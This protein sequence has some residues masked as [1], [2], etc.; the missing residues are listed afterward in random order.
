M[1]FANRENSREVSIFVIIVFFMLSL[2]PGI[3]KTLVQKCP[4]GDDSMSINNNNKK[5]V[6]GE[7]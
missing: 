4:R 7:Y 6:I 1:L 3:Q 5:Y 2:L